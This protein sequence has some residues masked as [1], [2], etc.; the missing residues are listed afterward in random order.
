MQVDPQTNLESQTDPL[1][2]ELDP[3]KTAIIKAI[4]VTFA[5]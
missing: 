1:N 4:K 2:E 3:Q 5:L